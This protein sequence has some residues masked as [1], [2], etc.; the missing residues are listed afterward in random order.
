MDSRRES[1]VGAL[2]VERA[3]QRAFYREDELRLTSR[4]FGVLS[5]LAEHPGWVLTAAQLA[6]EADPRGVASPSAVN[7]HIS[8]LRAKLAAA[9]GRNLITTVRGVGWRLRRRFNSEDDGVRPEGTAFLGR[10][11]E[12]A[13]L[14]GHLVPAKGRFA[15]VAGGLGIGKTSLVEHVLASA[16]PGFKVIRAACDAPGSGEHSPWQHILAEIGYESEPSPPPLP[17]P[18]PQRL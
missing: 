3:E 9:G 15:L 18:T 2:L 16:A 8:H 7:V 14:L 10:A 5:A 1:R 13:A 11:E 4:E 12:T 17:Q 6:D